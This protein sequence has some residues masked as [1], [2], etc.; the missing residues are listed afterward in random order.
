MEFS[1][2]V[3]L[4]FRNF[5]CTFTVGSRDANV[6]P[7]FSNYPETWRNITQRLLSWQHKSK[8][9]SGEDCCCTCPPQLS[10]TG[11]SLSSLQAGVQ[12]NE[13]SFLHVPQPPT[14]S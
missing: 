4:G 2:G 6:S 14:S 3:A 8:L 13:S 9:G 1:F 5:I 12:P 10:E 11:S 7:S